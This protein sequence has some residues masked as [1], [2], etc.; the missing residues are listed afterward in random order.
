MTSG[1]V[2]LN[3]T[4]ATL[5][6]AAASS[7]TVYVGRG[8]N[9]RSVQIFNPDAAIDIYLGTATVTSGTGYKL[10][11]GTSINLVLS[12]SDSLYAI[13]ASATPTVHYIESGT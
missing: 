1:Q 10:L 13:S 5:V 4:T 6:V 11:H 3:S 2:A 7:N 8:S 12:A 9:P